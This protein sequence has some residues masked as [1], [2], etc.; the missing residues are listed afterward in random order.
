MT[1]Y[2]IKDNSINKTP[3]K[4]VRE[5]YGETEQSTIIQKFGDTTTKKQ[6]K[7]KTNNTPI[8][9]P[10]NVFTILMEDGVKNKEQNLE[11]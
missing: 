10:T 1:W 7:N 11:I 2:N 6:I 8:I 5:F 4:N 3:A 9:K